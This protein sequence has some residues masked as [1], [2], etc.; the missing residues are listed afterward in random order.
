M[1]HQLIAERRPGSATM[2]ELKRTIA[3]TISGDSTESERRN[4]DEEMTLIPGSRRVLTRL[5][6]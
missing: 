1:P 3:K 2:T 5:P 4:A 6:A